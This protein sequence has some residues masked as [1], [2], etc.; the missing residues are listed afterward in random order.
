MVVL[1]HD[2]DI[3]A[4]SSLAAISY[5]AVVHA[6]VHIKTAPSAS[7]ALLYFCTAFCFDF[8]VL[9]PASSRSDLFLNISRYEFSLQDGVQSSGRGW[10]PR[11]CRCQCTGA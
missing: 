4:G 7:I 8:I 1:A 6:A 2:A 3:N 9:T 5:L 10:Q 11:L